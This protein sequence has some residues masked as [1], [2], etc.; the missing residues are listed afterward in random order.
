MK[1][2]RFLPFD[3][4]TLTSRLSPAEV[5]KR[6]TDSVQRK[7]LTLFKFYLRHADKPYEGI[8]TEHSFEI[9]RIIN[10]KNSFLPVIKGEFSYFLGK[11]EISVKMRPGI[12]VLVLTAFWFPVIGLINIGSV[13]A[14][15][16]Y[17]KKGKSLE[18]AILVFIPVMMLAFGYGLI[19]FGYKREAKK[20]KK[21]L[22]DLV[23]GEE[24][25]N[26]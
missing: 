23:Q 25:L 4:F 2:S 3:K 20:S 22:I 6:L 18:F 24:N 5:R 7:K 15:I 19:M 17:L 12:V 14:A 11:T 9:R 13:L 16:D 8:V 10:Y 26:L 1:A 21:F